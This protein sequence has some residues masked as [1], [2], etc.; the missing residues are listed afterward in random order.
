[1]SILGF[2][3]YLGPEVIKPTPIDFTL[4]KDV[5]LNARHAWVRELDEAVREHD[6]WGLL[7]TRPDGDVTL[8]DVSRTH[9]LWEATDRGGTIHLLLAREGASRRPA[10]RKIEAAR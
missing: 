1:V 2:D 7:R 6:A 4:P 3:F 10:P 8:F 5:V 9:A